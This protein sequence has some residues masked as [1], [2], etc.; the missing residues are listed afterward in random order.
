L[1]QSHSTKGNSRR[2]VIHDFILSATPQLCPTNM[3]FVDTL[4]KALASCPALKYCL[5][6]QVEIQKWSD[7]LIHP[8]F[9]LHGFAQW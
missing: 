8:N 6:A 7:W 9:K 5:L 4:L 3:S 2:G 1:A